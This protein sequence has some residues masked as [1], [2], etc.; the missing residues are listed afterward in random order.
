[1]TKVIMISISLAFQLGFFVSSFAQAIKLDTIIALPFEAFSENYTNLFVYDSQVYFSQHSEITQSI[2]LYNVG[3]GSQLKINISQTSLTSLSHTLIINN[4]VVFGSSVEAFRQKLDAGFFE[5]LE[6]DLKLTS[7]ASAKKLV[8]LENYP[9]YFN[10]Q[11]KVPFEV[12][13]SNYSLMF[14]GELPFDFPNY[15]A[16]VGSFFAIQDS[17]LVYCMATNYEC[18]M[19]NLN[20]FKL[21]NIL[22]KELNDKSAQAKIEAVKTEVMQPQQ[23]AQAWLRKLQELDKEIIRIERVLFDGNQILVVKRMPDSEWDYR[24]VDI[25][26]FENLTATLIA[27]D[28]K[29]ESAPKGKINY[30]NPP[31]FIM[32]SNP[33]LFYDSKLYMVCQFD[34]S[35]GFKEGIEAEEF[36][37]NFNRY[38]ENNIPKYAVYVYSIGAC[39]TDR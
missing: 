12:Y 7:L 38:Y 39:D 21:S 2:D 15:F 23:Q 17:L 20:S 28:S 18:Y 3:A 9:D 37:N 13:D 5:A 31:S 1:M 24:L 6:I 29:V 14:Q 36:T 10:P 27:S 33:I 16:R 22:H 32:D 30:S 11:P 19:L 26:S 4:E 35:E 34:Y 8:T 25:Y